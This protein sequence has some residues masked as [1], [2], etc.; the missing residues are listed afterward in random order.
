MT[1]YII[2]SLFLLLP[3]LAVQAQDVAIEQ[4]LEAEAKAEATSEKVVEKPKEMLYVTDELRL[5]LYPNA[6]D[7]GKRLE[8]L[9]SGDKLGILQIQG[10]YALVIAPTG[11][12]GWVKRGFLLP[13]PTAK[14]LLAEEKKT[15]EALRQ[16]IEKLANSKMVIDQYERDMDELTRNLNTAETGKL[17]AEQTVAEME[18][19]AREKA[20]LEAA[21]K[22]ARESK[23]TLPIEALIETAT[24]Y[25]QYLVPILVFFLLLGSLI[26]KLIINARI[27]KRFHG[28]KLW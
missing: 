7:R 8:Y 26:S 5:S 6:N 1:K 14:L 13:Q 18:A 3:S 10:P 22:A 15:T 23:T 11:R 19:A 20:E 2:A 4:A 24:T 27:K 12:R 21:I 25:W 9:N 16:E 17:N 28:L